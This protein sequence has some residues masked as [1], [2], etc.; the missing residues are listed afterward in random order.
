MVDG[1]DMTDGP[2]TKMPETPIDKPPVTKET[3][4]KVGELDGARGTSGGDGNV[5]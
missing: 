5:G 1:T 3:W 2:G 4:S